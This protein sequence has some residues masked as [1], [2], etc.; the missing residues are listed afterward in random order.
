M[1]LRMTPKRARI[2][3]AL[4]NSKSAL[5][6]QA[7]H[8]RVPE[9][10]LVTVYRTLD[11]FVKE[12]VVHKVLLDSDEAQFEYRTE[13]HHHAICTECEKVLHFTAPDK[14]IAALLGL[15]DFD[16]TSMEV[17]VRGKCVNKKRRTV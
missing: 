17:I 9:I 11:A 15:T 2:L 14:K 7:L 16:I 13:A 12:G 6:A 1:T 4:Q 5:S 8:Q 3:N 10:D